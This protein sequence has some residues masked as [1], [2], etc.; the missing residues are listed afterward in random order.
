MEKLQLVSQRVAV[1]VLGGTSVLMALVIVAGIAGTEWWSQLTGRRGF[2]V[3]S[4]SMQPAIGTGDYAVVRILGPA[5][6]H[7]IDLGSVITFRSPDDRSRIITHRV[8]GVETVDG[9][10]AYTTKGDAN[11]AADAPKVPADDVIGVHDFDLPWVGYV[12]ESAHHPPVSAPVVGAF[13]LASFALRSG[14]DGRK[15]EEKRRE[16]KRRRK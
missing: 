6:R 11:V 12:L 1:L 7:S 5:A 13:L 16:T 8:V 9:Q 10:S 15:E 4:G 14:G 2:V 3:S